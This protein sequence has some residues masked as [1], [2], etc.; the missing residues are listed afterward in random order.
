MDCNAEGGS[1]EVSNIYAEFE[2][3]NMFN[4][5]NESNV[6]KSSN[7]SNDLKSSNVSGISRQL[8]YLSAKASAQLDRSDKYFF[9]W[10]LK[11]FYLFQIWKLNP[12]Q[13]YN[14]NI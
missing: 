13:L 2:D 12:P 11:L 1:P 9:I 14:I 8:D 6:F 10:N 3:D 5:F 7:V 4:V